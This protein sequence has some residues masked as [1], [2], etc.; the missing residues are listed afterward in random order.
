MVYRYATLRD[1]KTALD[2]HRKRNRSSLPETSDKVPICHLPK[3]GL[4]SLSPLLQ[5]R[6]VPRLGESFIHLSIQAVGGGGVFFDTGQDGG[7]YQN[8]PARLLLS[9]LSGE[10]KSDA[11]D[12]TLKGLFPRSRGWKFGVLPR[13]S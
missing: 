3:L 4:S 1:A 7:A 12:L 8:F 6:P 11:G 2:E 10:T 13:S 5:Q 9:L